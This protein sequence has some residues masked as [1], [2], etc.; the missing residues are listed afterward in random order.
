MFRSLRILLRDNFLKDTKLKNEP[1]IAECYVT[2]LHKFMF[3]KIVKGIILNLAKTYLFD[4][5]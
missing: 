5:S 2:V 4:C 1:Q 3:T